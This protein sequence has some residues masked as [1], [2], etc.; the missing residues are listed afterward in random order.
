VSRE[1]RE[2]CISESLSNF[3]T[4]DFFLCGLVLLSETANYM[5]IPPDIQFHFDP[6]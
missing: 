4:F 2:T 1:V 6:S 5:V 3:K